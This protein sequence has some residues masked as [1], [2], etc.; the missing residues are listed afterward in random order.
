MNK[1][2]VFDALPIGMGQSDP[3]PPFGAA[4]A[5]AVLAAF[6]VWLTVRIVNRRERWTK[7]TLAAVVALPVLYV[8]SFGPA[9]WLVSRMEDS[10]SELP[11]VYTPLGWLCWKS[12]LVKTVLHAYGRLGISGEQ[13]VMYPV[14][15]DTYQ[16]IIP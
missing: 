1:A 16:A 4:L 3:D 6:S 10:D 2:R 12:P 11:V 7:W 8:A 5:L 15:E 14:G 13:Q 9:C